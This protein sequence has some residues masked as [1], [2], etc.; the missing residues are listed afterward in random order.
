MRYIRGCKDDPLCDIS[1]DTGALVR[2]PYRHV[3]N[4]LEDA[5]RK[6]DP[7]RRREL[8]EKAIYELRHSRAVLEERNRRDDLFHVAESEW[9]IGN[10]CVMLGYLGEARA[11]YSRAHSY[12]TEYLLANG[13]P[14]RDAWHQYIKYEGGL[15]RTT[16]KFMA[17]NLIA[18]VMIGVA[19]PSVG[20]LRNVTLA[21]TAVA[22][23]ISHK[24]A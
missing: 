8:I 19:V 21:G 24:R 13:T 23:V 9:Y 4:L 17:K 14:V 11:S 15:N 12:A 18:G 20:A 10:C 7:E 5:A 6:V 2:A 16:A 1:D 22:T 3:L